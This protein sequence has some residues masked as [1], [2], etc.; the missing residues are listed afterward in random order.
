MRQYAKQAAQKLWVV[1]VFLDQLG[2]VHCGKGGGARGS[3]VKRAVSRMALCVQQQIDT[4]NACLGDPVASV[5][6]DG[7]RTWWRLLHGQYHLMHLHAVEDWQCVTR[8]S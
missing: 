6:L 3:R 4:F 7:W 5:M 1:P 2:D 8:T